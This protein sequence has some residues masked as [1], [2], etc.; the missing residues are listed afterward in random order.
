MSISP[1]QEQH[2]RNWHTEDPVDEAEVERNNQVQNA[3][4]NR[5][6]FIDFPHLVDDI[7]DF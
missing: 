7:T 6:P 5:N 2:L 4:G 3:Q 1:T